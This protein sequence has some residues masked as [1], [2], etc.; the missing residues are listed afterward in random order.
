M[1][2][3]KRDK[4][5]KNESHAIQVGEHKQMAVFFC[6]IILMKEA[7]LTSCSI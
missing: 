1:H 6:L 5:E 2:E 4:E 7:V 3:K